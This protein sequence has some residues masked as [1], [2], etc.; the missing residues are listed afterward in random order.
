MHRGPMNRRWA[1][2]IGPATVT[3]STFV[4]LSVNSAK[5]LSRWASRCFAAL[6]MTGLYHA[7]LYSIWWAFLRLMPIRAD[8]SAVGAINLSLSGTKD[9][10]PTDDRINLV[11][12]IIALL[13]K[14]W[15][16]HHATGLLNALLRPL[17]EKRHEWRTGWIEESGACPIQK[18]G[19]ASHILAPA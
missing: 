16:I 13:A 14:L 7:R 11:L 19:T 15:H 5:G 2:S 8:E 6:S 3:L 12:C 9:R 4:S 17:E 10:P 18:R 1:R